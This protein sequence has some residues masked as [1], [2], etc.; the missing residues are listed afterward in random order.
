MNNL[1]RK[2]SPLFQI[3]FQPDAATL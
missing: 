3:S 1:N 2:V